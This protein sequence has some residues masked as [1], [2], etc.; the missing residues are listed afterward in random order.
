MAVHGQMDLT[1][2]SLR[3]K[4]GRAG[5]CEG[6]EGSQ[7]EEVVSSLPIEREN[8]L[9]AEKTHIFWISRSGS[10]VGQGP[11]RTFHKLTAFKMFVKFYTPSAPAAPSSPVNDNSQPRKRGRP[12]D[13]DEAQI[14]GD[15]TRGDKPS[16]VIPSIFSKRKKKQRVIETE[17][18]RDTTAK[19]SEDRNNLLADNSYLDTH[20]DSSINILPNA[21]T[22]GKF[23]L[24]PGP[25]S[26]KP[27]KPLSKGSSTSTSFK[28]GEFLSSS[29]KARFPALHWST[30]LK[31][32]SSRQ[33]LLLFSS[34]FIASLYCFNSLCIYLHV[35]YSNEMINRFQ[36][37]P[38]R[39]IEEGRKPG[40][41][42]NGPF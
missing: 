35:F 1:S 34:V 17:E 5:D 30:S 42:C 29:F 11:E 18:Q 15:M 12:K 13:E 25:S 24:T 22:S 8:A 28:T 32:F 19:P 38:E 31:R 2:A 23:G 20:T 4:S 41:G 27:V 39:G 14:L 33:A 6:R 16:T 10:R 21:A 36:Y 7:R 9:A 26:F 40:M 3:R 37:D